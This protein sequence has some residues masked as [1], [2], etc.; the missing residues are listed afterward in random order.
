MKRFLATLL[1]VISAACTTI[2]D[3]SPN[4]AIAAS[5]QTVEVLVDQATTAVLRGRI[6]P[7]QGVK[8]KQTS[9]KARAK[10]AQAEEALKVCGLDI[11]NC[12]S[13]QKILDQVQPLLIEMERELQKKEKQ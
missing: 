5:Y 2:S 8:V 11:K 10:I 1:I 13:V 3:L 4:A 7:E 12:D 9:E 6:T